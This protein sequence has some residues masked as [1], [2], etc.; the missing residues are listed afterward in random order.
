MQR[1]LISYFPEEYSPSNSQIE[2]INGVEKALINNKKFIICCA[3][4]GTG[5]SFIAKTLANYSSPPT[6]EYIELVNT[7]KAF[8]QDHLG[9][10]LHEA[11]CYK[12]PAF[13]TFTLTITKSLQDQYLKLF[14]DA[15]L[16]KG[17]TNYQCQVDLDVDVEVAPCVL[18]SKLKDDCWEKN[19]CPYYNA[20]NNSLTDKFSILNYKMFLSL[21]AHI[22]KKNFLICDEASELEDELVKQFSAFI[23]YEKLKNY[24]I[25]ITPLVTDKYEKIH[26][27]L[28]DVIFQLSETISSYT[29]KQYKKITNFSP[30]DKI[31]INYL[32][33]LYK[34]L[35]VIENLWE[36]N[37]FIVEKNSK[38][39]TITPLRINKLTKHIFD[40][41][42]HIILM[43]A[44]II[45]HKNFAKNL[46]IKD[47]SYIEVA[48]TFD[49]SKSP[50][51]VTSKHKL[52]YKNIKLELPKVAEKIKS[53]CNFHSNEKG[54]I[55]THT[56]DITEYLKSR[57]GT[58]RFLYRDL[59][60]RNEDIL[61][62]HKLK[63]GP[64]IL[65][66]PSLAFGIDLKD[67]LARFQIITK[68]PY[69]PLSSKRIKKLFDEDKDWYV[70]KMLNSLVQA[71]GRATRSKT[72]Y[73][74]TYILDGNVVEVLK[75]HKDK[76]P[77]YFIDR[78]I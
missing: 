70:D 69:L 55:H 64:T 7:Y 49:S 24:G 51:Y 14:T 35:S 54:I 48:S 22:K 5:K 3:P 37:E 17:K 50:I 4:T 9:N 73:S 25:E 33:N 72:D 59:S 71:C 62:E 2:L 56:M 27:W 23:D 28:Y 68:L 44:T 26:V 6:Q 58:H 36:Q 78:I 16:L 21:P 52:N 77:K 60:S 40:F 75:K 10:F 13:G 76:L 32:K 29:N 12:Q 45:D 46:G 30:I 8:K 74:T 61:K 53:I 57:L 15:M 47:Y 41:A 66:S 67:H 1:K 34:N 63:D 19:L 20:R 11:D 42:E 39:V 31:K 18:A 43:S 38:K 65:V